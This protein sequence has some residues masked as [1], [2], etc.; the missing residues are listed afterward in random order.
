MRLTPSEHE[1]QS[2]ILEYLALHRI[3][4]R[5]LNTG[6]MAGAHKGKRWFVRFGKKGDPDII[7][8]RYPHLIAIEVKGATGQLRPEQEEFRRD[9]EARAGCTYIVARRLED[10]SEVLEGAK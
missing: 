8:Y 10:V 6:T 9:F 2:A 4:H 5:R 1:V 3:W 7:A